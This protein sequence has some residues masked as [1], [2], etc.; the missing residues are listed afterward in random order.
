MLTIRKTE[1]YADWFSGLRDL[2][3]QARI[4]TRIRRLVLGNPGD[5][6]PVGDGNSQLMMWRSTSTFFTRKRKP[7]I[8]RIPVP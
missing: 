1:E 2:Q 4:Q 5:V 8:R 3:A 6:K 7:S